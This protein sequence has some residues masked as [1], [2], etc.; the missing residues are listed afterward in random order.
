MTS[1]CQLAFDWRGGVPESGTWWEP[2]IDGWRALYFRGTD[3]K[4]R[5]WTRGGIPIEGIAHILHRLSAMERAA[6]QSMFFDGEFQ[7]GGTLADTKRWCERGWKLGGE[8]GTFYAFDCMPEWQWRAG[9]CDDPLI[10][11][12]ARLVE[13]GRA[14][15]DDVALSWEWR[16]GSRGRDA[17][18][19]PVE[20]L[21]DGWAFDGEDV[22]SEARRIW[23]AGGEGLMLKDAEAPYRRNRNAAW[24]KV[25]QENAGRWRI[26]A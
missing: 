11:R 13:L 4:P 15:D 8:A 22:L 2:K 10:E 16:E 12:K 1:L 5:L 7:V 14:A 24:Q 18:G 21:A 25:K 17:G 23:A 19:T 6:G 3:G 20:V 9:G 26:A